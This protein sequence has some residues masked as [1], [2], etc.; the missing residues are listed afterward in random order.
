[1]RAR[2]HYF[3]RHFGASKI[4]LTKARLL[5][6]DFPVHGKRRLESRN[7]GSSTASAP[8]TPSILVS[9]RAQVHL[10][11]HLAIAFP[12]ADQTMTYYRQ[13]IPRTNVGGGVSRI[14]EDKWAIPPGWLGLSGSQSFP[15]NSPREY[16][17]DPP[18]PYN[19]RHLK[20]PE[21]LPPPP[22]WLGTLLFSEV[23]PER[24]SQRRSH[25]LTRNYY[26][27]NSLRII[28]RNFLGILS[29]SNFFSRNYV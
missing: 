14:D 17:W 12:S 22:G 4:A 6:H 13:T 29:S 3:Q 20:V 26:E 2:E 15:W 7:F 27:N 10:T 16:G 18:K 5:K 25:S 1:M 9:C 11:Y 24:A 21:L 8:L 23:V 19:S 28:F